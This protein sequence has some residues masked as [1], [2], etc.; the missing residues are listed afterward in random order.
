MHSG[1]WHI[2]SSPVEDQEL[3]AF[4]LVNSIVKNNTAG[5]YDM[6]PYNEVENA[7]T[8]YTEGTNTN[9]FEQARAYS[10]RRDSVGI[11]EF[12]GNINA[13]DIKIPGTRTADSYGWNG[14]GNPYT[15]PIQARGLNSFFIAN[16]SIFDPAFRA[17]YIWDQSINDYSVI[18]DT[19]LPILPE[20]KDTLSFD[21]IALGQGFVIKV[22]EDADSV[23]FTRDMQL[24]INEFDVPFK[25]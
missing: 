3:G 12:S 17:L 11:V 21:G 13:G 14:V 22:K 7:W 16:A 9:P 2:V 6:A 1:N 8:P 4:S 15:S 5:D 19:D 18:L 20:I 10:I 23:S 24:H 25:I